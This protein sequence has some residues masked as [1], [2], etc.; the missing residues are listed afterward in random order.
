MWAEDVWRADS[1]PP[2]GWD[3]TTGWDET[4][5]S[6]VDL[7][8]FADELLAAR[9]RRGLR[10]RLRLAE[11]LPGGRV[12]IDG[13]V[14]INFSSNDYLGLA[15]DPRVRAA[16][17]EAAHRWGAGAGASRLITG[18]H[19]LLHELEARL[20]AWKGSEDAVVLGSG[21]LANLSALTA[22]AGREDVILIDALAH[23]CLWAGARLSRARILPFCHN[24]C[25][26]IETKL[27]RARA[28]HRHAWILTE[29]V[30]SMDGDRAPLGA[31]HALAHRHDAFLY[32]DDAHGTGVLAGGR[33]SLAA[34]GVQADVQMGTLS[35]ALGS[36]GG[37]VA[38]ARPVAELIR[39]RGWGFV[40]TTGLPPAAVGA[41]LAALAILEAEPERSARP[42]QLAA[43][44]AAAV[45]LPMPASAIVPIL[46]GTAEA[47]LAA[48]RALE[49]RGFLAV[50][51][52][53]P[54][55]PEGTARLRL[56]FS[57]AHREEDVDALAAA[58][59]ELGLLAEDGPWQAAAS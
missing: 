41:A 23:S 5:D 30:F 19:P 20:A 2:V 33:G 47:A 59:C 32:V 4:G 6:M 42:L 40:Y 44:F 29:G 13:R 45:G 37:F 17:A 22:L 14:C 46:L 49:D 7:A 55:V 53:P 28:E 57:A 43:R 52:R 50:A 9:T 58:V 48:Q 27:A 34:A 39:N 36:Y 18:S 16:A 12:Q 10:R 51:I 35:K 15:G 3:E 11:G 21:Y 8:A 31:L 56:S 1:I 25:S 26:D 38:C 24:D 54:T